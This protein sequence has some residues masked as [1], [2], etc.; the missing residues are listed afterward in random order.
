MHIQ[1]LAVDRGVV[2]GQSLQSEDD[3]CRDTDSGSKCM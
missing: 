2:L 3:F 1:N